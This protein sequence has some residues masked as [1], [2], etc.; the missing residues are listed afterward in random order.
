M[1]PVTRR[2]FLKALPPTAHT[3]S[4]AVKQEAKEG[5]TTPLKRMVQS[6]GRNYFGRDLP[7]EA[8]KLTAEG[9]RVPRRSVVRLFK[10]GVAHG[11]LWRL[12]DSSKVAKTILEAPKYLNP[13]TLAEAIGKVDSKINASNPI[14]KP[15]LRFI[16]KLPF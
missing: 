1:A 3:L 10:Q 5:V 14:I 6:H 12:D 16:Q 4:R 2:A 13:Q 8:A 7:V 9:N 11:M 15:F